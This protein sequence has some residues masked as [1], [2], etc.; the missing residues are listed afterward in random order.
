M[1]AFDNKTQHNQTKADGTAPAL[2]PD[3]DLTIPSKGSST[4][5][6][7][8]EKALNQALPA[9]ESQAVKSTPDDHDHGPV[10]GKFQL[11]VDLNQ[12]ADAKTLNGKQIKR[13]TSFRD[14]LGAKGDYLN[15]KEGNN[16]V[17]GSGDSDVIRGTGRGFN[18]ITTGTGKDTV[19]LGKETTNRVLDF[20][21]GNDRFV[22][23]GL[24]PRNITIAQG[25]NPG[26]G[27]LDQPLDSV[28]N[29][30]VIDKTNGHILASLPFVKAADISEKNFARNTAEANRSLRGLKDQG[31]KTQRGNG[32]LTGTQGH[33]RLIG[34]G[35]DDFL[36]VGDDGFKLNT[37]KG[38]GKT[39]F[40]FRVDDT[41][42]TTELTPE[43]KNGVLRV[44]GSYKDLEAAPLFSQGEKEID[45]KAKILN[46]SDPK[47]LIE[48]FLK[49][50]KDVEGNPISGTHLH[51][52]PS[53][54]ARGSFADATV[55]RYFTN[56][57]TDAR[58]GTIS[59]EFELSPTE[60][61]ALLAGDFYTNLHTNVDVDGD[62]K[63]GF[64]TGENRI[65]FNRDVVQFT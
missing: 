3:A 43:L 64:P 22:L 53:G 50:P 63:A 17:I 46:G 55:V 8:L 40:P 34:G 44:K 12:V 35:G 52:S 18:T 62:G 60:Q 20:D 37:A 38:S 59:G 10:V 28:N 32:K 29:A 24:N 33:D 49:V 19:I 58:S 57:P 27:G 2:S 48:G 11:H 23:S 47:A 36:Y 6:T 4:Q 16:V 51:F 65:N 39:E 13:D 21:P 15:P 26:K 56:T 42:G 31:F 61:A 5:G 14:D 54:D 9:E 1:E 25:K 7:E 45:P 41:A 30:L